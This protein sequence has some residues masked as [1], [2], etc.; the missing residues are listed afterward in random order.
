MYIFLVSALTSNF[1]KL[2]KIYLL[3]LFQVTRYKYTT[4]RLRAKTKQIFLSHTHG[5]LHLGW[6]ETKNVCSVFALRRTIGINVYKKNNLQVCIHSTTVVASIKYPWQIS[7]II[8][9]FT[10]V[11]FI[12]FIDWASIILEI[13]DNHRIELTTQSSLNVCECV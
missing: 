7:H 1:C 8:Q 6:R 13:S 3:Y 2:E 4:V 10:L 5:V 12:L 9:L 11:N